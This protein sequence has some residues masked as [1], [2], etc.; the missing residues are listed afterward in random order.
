MPSP[1]ELVLDAG[2]LPLFECGAALL[3]LLAFPSATDTERTE[4]EASLCARHLRAT[5]KESGNPDEL[6]KAKYAFRDEELIKTDL[7][8]LDR[9]VRDRMVAAEVAIPFLQ[10]AVGHPPRLPSG[11]K[12]LSINQLSEY[13]MG[14]AEQ[15]IPENFKSRVWAPSVPVIH[16]AAAVAVAIN[17]RERRGEMKTSY[18]NIIADSDLLFDVLTNAIEFENIIKN[19]KLRIDAK[20]LV[21]IRLVK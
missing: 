14:R 17:E 4:I 16:I 11:V 9:L 3:A 12:R 5:F 8:V 18:G 21:S 1:R 6:V 20:K 13:L 10:K 7:K 15:S 19:N 2:R